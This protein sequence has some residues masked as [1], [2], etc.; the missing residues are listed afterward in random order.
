MKH[1]GALVTLLSLLMLVAACHNP[2]SDTSRAVT[3][4]AARTA[5]P[6]TAGGHKYAITPQNSKIEFVG[7]KVTGSHNGSFEKFNGEIDY[8][9]NDPTQSHVKI[10]I[11]MA[12]VKVDDPKLTEH[13]KTPDFFDVA[14][15]AEAKFESTAIKAGGDK[16]ASHTV[17]GNLTLHGVT[18]SVTFPATISVT[19]D[20][21]TVD[22]NFAINRK[23][24]GINYAGA[25]DNLIRDEV[26]MTLRIRANK[27]S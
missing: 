14:K 5:S 4:E 26:V 12:S 7:S 10:T 17:T 13:L 16:G 18:K 24:F 19:P 8:A 25:A 9:N 15:H 22:A 27:G 23:D 3:G 21:A 1:P 2:A 11:D 20:V 6:Q